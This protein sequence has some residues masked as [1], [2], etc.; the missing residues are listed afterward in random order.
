M[1]KIVDD[2]KRGKMVMSMKGL[3]KCL[4]FSGEDEDYENWR[5]KNHGM[6]EE[7]MHFK[8]MVKGCG[9]DLCGMR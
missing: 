8:E 9:R 1:E 3:S 4:V 2:R 5:K 7:Y 6:F